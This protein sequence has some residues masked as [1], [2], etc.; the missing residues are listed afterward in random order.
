M[1]Q[2]V[3]IKTNHGMVSY[4]AEALVRDFDTDSMVYVHV[5]WY[6]DATHYTVSAEPLMG[7]EDAVEFQEEYRSLRSAKKSG[8]GKVFEV[9]EKVLN[10]MA[11]TIE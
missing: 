5:N 3:E 2:I 10:A 6:E 1:K 11:E 4:D 7:A 9:L 8:Y